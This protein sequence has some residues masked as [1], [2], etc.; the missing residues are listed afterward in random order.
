MNYRVLRVFVALCSLSC[1]A[2]LCAQDTGA[3]PERTT[4]APTYRVGTITVKFVGTASVNE[5]VV[6]ANMQVRE[7]GELD[8]TMLDRDIRALYRTG[9]FEFIEIKRETVDSQT[10]NLVVEVTP[11]YRVLSITYEGNK[12]IKS[13]RLGRQIKSTPN[14]VLDERQVKEDAEKLKEYY[15]KLGYNQVSVSYTIKRDRATGLG[16]VDVQ[17]P[18][19]QEGEDQAGQVHRQRPHQV[20]DAAQADGDEEVVDVL[21]AH[22]L[23]PLQGRRVPGRPGQA[24]GLLPRARLPR[25]RHPRGEDRLQL[26]E[27]DAAS[28]SP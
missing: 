21:L 26:P 27:A 13:R 4:P 9:L 15:Q 3:A 2:R 20:E 17:D 5:Q 1:S 12:E 11:K 18:G 14:T 8:E 6:R 28:S 19:G 16:T 7:G 10:V 23:R 22:G 25:R 24:E